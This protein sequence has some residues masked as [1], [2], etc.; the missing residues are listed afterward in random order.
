MYFFP[1]VLASAAAAADGDGW[2]GVDVA[3]KK[4]TF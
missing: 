1:F 3:D 2:V 4:M